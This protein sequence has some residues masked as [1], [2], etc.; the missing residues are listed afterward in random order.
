MAQQIVSLK[1]I[2]VEIERVNKSLRK[3]ARTAPR[4]Q[5]AGIRRDVQIL[6]VM[7]KE[8]QAVC[9]KTYRRTIP[10]Y[11]IVEEPVRRTS[12]RERR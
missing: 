10:P 3:L 5:S 4:E 2:A 6:D 8:V 11:D 12:R 1:S 9:G 7:I